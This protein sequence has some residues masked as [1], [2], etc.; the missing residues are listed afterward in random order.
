MNKIIY[1]F[2]GLAS[3]ALFTGCTTLYSVLPNAIVES[4]DIP[5]RNKDSSHEIFFRTESASNFKLI[6][7]AS[8]RPLNLNT[9]P[10]LTPETMVTAGLNMTTSSRFQYGFAIAPSSIWFDD[11]AAAGRL[12]AK[13]QVFSTE[14]NKHMISVFGHVIGS[15]SRIRGT[16][17]ELFGPGGYPWKANSDGWGLNSGISYGYRFNDN[18][19]MYLGAAYESFGMSASV[20]QDASATGDDPAASGNMPYS[21]GYSRTANLG[22]V[23]GKT[24]RMTLNYSLGDTHWNSMINSTHFLSFGMSFAD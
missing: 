1:L 4:P 7:D 21:K 12:M 18:Y 20:T 22:L 14:N 8:E 3:Y 5:G 11:F 19:F 13:F 2:L 9:P 17:K 15:I 23:W 16:Q 10:E 6:G 24:T